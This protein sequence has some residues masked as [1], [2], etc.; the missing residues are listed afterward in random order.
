MVFDH[1]YDS[2][3][4]Q[5][6]YK[7]TATSTPLTSGCDTNYLKGYTWKAIL[8]PG[9]NHFVAD[10][11]VYIIVVCAITASLFLFLGAILFFWATCSKDTC[12]Q[13]DKQELERPITE[14]LDYMEHNFD[15]KGN[16]TSN[17]VSDDFLKFHGRQQDEGTDK[18]YKCTIC[19]ALVDRHARKCSN[20]QN[21]VNKVLEYDPVKRKVRI[22][23][24]KYYV[25]DDD[26]D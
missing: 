12:K 23:N 8:Q 4:K 2:H 17:T 14:N 16:P 10:T 11:P 21:P 6:V 3:L 18:S 20:C 5:Y 24:N 13:A 1:V 25:L 7:V 9:K 19:R 22:K 15:D 26:Q